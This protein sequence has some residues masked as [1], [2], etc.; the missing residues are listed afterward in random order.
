MLLGYKKSDLVWNGASPGAARPSGCGG[1]AKPGILGNQPLAGLS[2][3]PRKRLV[4]I[5]S[6]YVKEQ[7]SFCDARTWTT[8]F[9]LRFR[10]RSLPFICS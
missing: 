7:V 10:R 4:V 3:S 9:V 1:L 8:P 6:A 5:K 2:K